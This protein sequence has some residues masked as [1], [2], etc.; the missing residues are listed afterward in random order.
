MNLKTIVRNLLAANVI[1]AFAAAPAHADSADYQIQ[2]ISPNPIVVLSNG[3]NYTQI[4]DNSPVI[5]EAQVYLDV[6]VSGSIVSWWVEPEIWT[7]VGIATEVGGM[8]FSRHSESYPFG[9]RPNTVNKTVDLSVAAGTIQDEAVSMCNTIA[10]GLRNNGASNAQ[11]F[12]QDRQAH[13]EVTLAHYQNLNGPGSNQLIVEGMVPMNLD[14]ICNRYQPPATPGGG[15]GIAPRVDVLGSS[16]GL[17]EIT[18]K[19]GTCQVRT[20]LQVQASVPNTQIDYR[21]VHSGVPSQTYGAITD[22]N[23]NFN[24]LRLWDIPKRPGTEAGWFQVEG[25]SATFKTNQAAYEMECQ[26][27]LGIDSG[28]ND[29]PGRDVISR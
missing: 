16:L 8:W 13:F 20:S 22:A 19:T 17:T 7:G 1:A 3:Q 26:H 25:V 29:S 23:G 2:S 18:T 12:G 14:V 9:N 11:I 15:G 24:M 21:Y 28:N 10:A 5:I 6:G 4:Q 27:T